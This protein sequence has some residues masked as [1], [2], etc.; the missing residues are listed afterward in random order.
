VLGDGE[1]KVIVERYA[2][3]E[4]M[5]ALAAAYECGEATIWRALR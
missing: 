4:T 2:K 5:A 1:R 3:G